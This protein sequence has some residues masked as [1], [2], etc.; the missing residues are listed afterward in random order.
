ME[1]NPAHTPPVD[2]F[3][4]EWPHV[5]DG[6]GRIVI[7]SRWRATDADRFFL[8][9]HPTLSHLE[10]LPPEEFTKVAM[11]VA[12][13]QGLSPQEARIFKR[14][15]Y[16]NAVEVEA[17]K[18]GRFTLPE[19]LRKLMKFERELTL[20]GVCETF[21]IWDAATRASL[22]E[23]SRSTYARALGLIGR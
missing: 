20:V 8:M 23:A 9:V 5:L 12:A 7:P 15:F 6:K 10:V 16:A 11:Q 2:R 13:A 17:D 19:T 3:T 4:G 22:R 14:E 21:E 18:Q 1:P